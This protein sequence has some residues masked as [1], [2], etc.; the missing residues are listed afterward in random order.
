M[1]IWRESGRERETSSYQSV[2][3]VHSFAQICVAHTSFCAYSLALFFY[4]HMYVNKYT[5]THASVVGVTL[6]PTTILS[7]TVSTYKATYVHTHTHM[8]IHLC[9]MQMRVKKNILLKNQYSDV[10]GNSNANARHKGHC[11]I[12]YKLKQ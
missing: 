6:M 2:M 11:V 10:D 12:Q 3:G 8:Y 7:S 4:I 9:T 1:C 5:H